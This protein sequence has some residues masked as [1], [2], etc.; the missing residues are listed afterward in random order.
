MC[1]NLFI[2]DCDSLKASFIFALPKKAAFYTLGEV[3]ERLK[4][5][6]C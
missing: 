4:P 2:L 6:V 1:Q 5:A 3:G